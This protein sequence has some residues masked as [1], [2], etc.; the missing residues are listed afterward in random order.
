MRK[1]MIV[2][3]TVAVLALTLVGVWILRGAAPVSAQQ[4]LERS[5]AAQEAAE[6]APG[7]RHMRS[8]KYV[9]MQG[10]PKGGLMD[11]TLIIE[12]YQDLQTGKQRL[13]VTAGENGRVIEAWAYDGNYVY[14]SKSSPGDAIG[15]LT[16]YRTPQPPG[17]PDLRPIKR[18]VDLPDAK[19]LFEKAKQDSN[20]HVVGQA[21]WSDGRRVYVLRLEQLGK[22]LANPK[23][24]ATD[25]PTTS[26]LYFDTGTYQLLGQEETVESNGKQTVVSS[27]RQLVQE[28]LPSSTPVAWDLHDLKGVTT[29]DDPDAEHGDQLPVAISHQE[30]VQRTKSA[31]MLRTLPEGF[32]VTITALPKP[33]P[34]EPDFYMVDYRDANENA[35]HIQSGT[36]IPKAMIQNVQEV[37]TTRSGLTLYFQGEEPRNSATVRAPD[38]TTFIITANMPRERVKAFAEDLVPVR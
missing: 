29:V 37:Y 16:I 6:A 38:G 27:F 20:A 31:Y 28:T 21:T 24:P 5:S 10:T 9:N 4:I 2:A 30:L 7:I 18:S 34:S 33:K 15:G 13:V 26:T 8:Q 17:A 22:A 1:R 11:G 19:R 23:Q 35:F 36:E 12:S 25:L 3:A 32:T 14:S